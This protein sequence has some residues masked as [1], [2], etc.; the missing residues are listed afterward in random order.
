MS[1]ALRSDRKVRAAKLCDVA[2]SRVVWQMTKLI[3]Q[4][5]AAARQLAGAVSDYLA[6]RSRYMA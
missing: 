6:S 1:G 5:C 3:L 2:D 4:S